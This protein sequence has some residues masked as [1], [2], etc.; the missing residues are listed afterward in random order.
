MLLSR[1]LKVK[2]IETKKNHLPA[3][4]NYGVLC[5]MLPSILEIT[6]KNQTLLPK[7]GYNW[8]NI[9]FLGSTHLVALVGIPLY[10]IFC[11]FH[12]FDIFFALAYHFLCSLGITVGY[13]RM[14]SHRAFKGNSVCE[15][16][17]LF[18]GGGTFEMSALDWCS[19]HRDHHKY[20]DTERDPYASTK[21][22]FY[23]H[24]GW[25]LFWIHDINHSNCRDLQARP[26]VV[27]QHRYYYYWAL[28]AGIFLPFILCASLGSVVGALVFA[29]CF[30][31]VLSYQATFCI[32]SV[33][34]IIG[35]KLYDAKSS[36]CDHWLSAILSSG[37]G[38]HN[39]HHRFPR[40]YRN[41]VRWYHWDPSKW[42]IALLNK[43]GLASKLYRTSRFA[44]LKERITIE[45]RTLEGI[46]QS[47][48]K[49]RGYDDILNL[50]GEK[51]TDVLSQLQNWEKGI[52]HYQEL[53][54]SY[55]QKTHEVLQTA[56]SELRQ[57]KTKFKQA[58][59][60]W[61]T[62]LLQAAKI[63]GVLSPLVSSYQTR[64]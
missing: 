42:I 32:N 61:K 38:Y 25:L 4:L 41:G 29:V 20:T 50:V 59:R 47:L 49:W 64:N 33:C 39:F 58:Q 9:I 35:S 30:R 46:L 11:D 54:S 60:E 44:I 26:L 63:E 36:A 5:T 23:S 1:D 27:H 57:A 48:N 53:K 2:L 3:N 56:K 52:S 7:K 21:G 16:F 19:Q 14:F 55:K 8:Q 15:F 24:V 18:F 51:Y 62:L 37:E 28:L 13:H 43:C 12:F 17:A 6:N 45:N 22:F 10:F 40:D 34:H 31:I